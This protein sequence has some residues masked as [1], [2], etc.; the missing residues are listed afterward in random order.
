MVASGGGRCRAEYRQEG[1]RTQPEKA[2]A[3]DAVV[4]RLTYCQNARMLAET[5]FQAIEAGAVLLA[6][7]FAMVQLHQYRR[8]KHREA[9]MELLHSFQTPSFARALNI[10]YAMPDGLSEEEIE[11]FA[12]DEFLLVYA[13]TTTWESLGVLVHRCEIDLQLI[14]DFFS[15][16]IRISWCKLERHVM[17]ERAATG[18][19]TINEWFQWLNEHLGELESKEPPVPAHIAHKD[20]RPRSEWWN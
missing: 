1:R 14:D 13:M 11:R 15:G 2:R 19:E 5:V 4:A 8:D 12:G 18:R 16:P 3:T 20:W 17:G 7:G 10:V 6:V 9:A